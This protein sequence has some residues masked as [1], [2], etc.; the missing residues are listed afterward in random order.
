MGGLAL[1]QHGSGHLVAAAAA[2]AILAVLLSQHDSQL[3]G[4]KEARKRGLK[5]PGSSE[6][7]TRP[8]V[9]RSIDVEK[10]MWFAH[11]SSSRDASAS[12]RGLIFSPACMLCGESIDGHA[13]D[14]RVVEANSEV[15]EVR[16]EQMTVRVKGE[17]H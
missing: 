1:P 8:Y 6:A 4:S 15:V 5:K 14:V 17:R 12:T 11:L 3:G 10:Q 16:F 9:A 2:V 13:T 7:Y